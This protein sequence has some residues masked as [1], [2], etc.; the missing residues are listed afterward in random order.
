ML[1]SFLGASAAGAAAS[2]LAPEQAA[3]STRLASAAACKVLRKVSFMRPPLGSAASCGVWNGMA[4]AGDLPERGDR[5]R[6]LGQGAVLEIAEGLR[7]LG[8]EMLA[9]ADGRGFALTERPQFHIVVECEEQRER[10]AF[11]ADLA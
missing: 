1:N 4:V 11:G 6:S 5:A 10:P 3:V 8:V 2:F 7:R 9:G